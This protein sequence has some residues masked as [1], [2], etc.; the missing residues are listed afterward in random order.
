MNGAPPLINSPA[1]HAAPRRTGWIVYSVIATFLLFVSVVAN[2]VLF[3]MALSPGGESLRRGEHFQE[4]YVR[5]D[6]ESRNK[7]AVINLF[8][9]ISYGG[10]NSASE[11]GI[12]G[13]IKDQLDQAVKDKRV[14]AIV[15]RIDSPGGEVVASDAIYRALADVR[16]DTERKLKI[17]ACIE[18]VGA[19]GAYYAAMGSDYVIANDLSITGS[20]GVILQSFT[21]GDLMGKIGVHSY[22]FKSGK[23]KDILNPTREPTEDEQALVQTL[24]MQVYEKFVG[25]VASERHMDVD[26]LKKGLADGRILS[27]KQALEAGFV[28]DVGHL[29]DAIK[30]AMNLANVKK[31][32]VIRYVR[33][34]SLRNLLQL[35]G[36]SG[37]AKI[38]VQL[39]PSQPKLQNGKLYFLPAYMFQ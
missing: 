25:I 26:A 34:F 18:S 29:D 38:Q 17:V 16:D 24:I 3:A 32:K 39:G 20:I 27:G 11:D 5:G 28:D 4:V 1:A 9:V 13:D 22:T 30:K 10:D 21:F 2:L 23:Y 7:V 31:A 15:L 6:E 14:K 36:K 19:S 35:F 12:V 8:G 33:P 37:D